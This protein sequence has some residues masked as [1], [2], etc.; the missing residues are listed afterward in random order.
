MWEEQYLKP[1][2]N[3]IAGFT[4]LK[5]NVQNKGVQSHCASTKLPTFV[6]MCPC[7]AV[8]VDRKSIKKY[9]FYEFRA[10]FRKM[11]LLLIHKP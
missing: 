6:Q 10:N 2:S 5:M 8:N 1:T 3:Y 11:Q 9:F 7:Q 4:R